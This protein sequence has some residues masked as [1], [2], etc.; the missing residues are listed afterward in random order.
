MPAGIGSTRRKDRA[1]TL[2][3]TKTMARMPTKIIF[4]R[5]TADRDFG[6]TVFMQPRYGKMIAGC[7]SIKMRGTLKKEL[8]G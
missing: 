1:G 7:E 8:V 4:R 2:A 6:F 3:Q 5:R